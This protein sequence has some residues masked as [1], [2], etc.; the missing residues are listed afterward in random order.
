MI[1]QIAVKEDVDRRVARQLGLG[2]QHA[3]VNAA[4]RPSLSGVH[5]RFD[6][7]PLPALHRGEHRGEAP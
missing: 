7:Q 3:Q 1:V 6:L 5:A 2:L 4:E